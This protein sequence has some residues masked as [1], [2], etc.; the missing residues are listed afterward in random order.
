MYRIVT[1]EQNI[2][3]HILLQFHGLKIRLFLSKSCIL[4]KIKAQ[5][6]QTIDFRENLFLNYG[7]YVER[8]DGY[9][10]ISLHS[11]NH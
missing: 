9:Y 10:F 11:N 5:W 2:H 8:I 1:Y 7:E 3:V 4:V 6:R